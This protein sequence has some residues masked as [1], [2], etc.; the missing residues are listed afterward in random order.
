MIS[1][2]SMYLPSFLATDLG[3]DLQIRYRQRVLPALAA[4]MEGFDNPRV[5]VDMV[6]ITVEVLGH[7]S[8]CEGLESSTW[9]G[10]QK[11]AVVVVGH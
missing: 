3:S 2:V 9:D 1:G 7:Y 8:D 4:S 6:K 11:L 5:Q 10:L